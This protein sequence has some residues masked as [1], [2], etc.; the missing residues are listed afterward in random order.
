MR[1]GEALARS[2][3]G[4]SLDRALQDSAHGIGCGRGPNEH[5]LDPGLF[6]KQMCDLLRSP[7]PVKILGLIQEGY[8][9]GS[10]WV[11]LATALSVTQH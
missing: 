1:A 4:A 10:F 5:P 6:Q 11:V 3:V 8:H 2:A 9:P 7:A